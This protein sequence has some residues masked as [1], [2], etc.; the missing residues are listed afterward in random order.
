MSTAYSSPSRNS[1]TMSDFRK[2]R[3]II[4]NR[5]KSHYRNV[6]KTYKESFDLKGKLENQKPLSKLE[7]TS[8]E[9]SSS[10]REFLTI[11]RA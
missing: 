6:S 2:G 9:G 3:L 1:K 10:T 4:L 11:H 7:S 8:G 5:R